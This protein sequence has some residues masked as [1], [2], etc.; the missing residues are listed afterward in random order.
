[1][2]DKQRQGR[3]NRQRGNA[4][5]RET[6]KKHG[7]RRT[8]MYGGPDDVTVDGL[9]K[10]QTKVGTMFSNKYWGWLEKIIVKAGEI[11]YL[12]IGDAPGAG[13]LRRVMVIMDER[14][15]IGIKE[16]LYGTAE[17]TTSAGEREPAVSK[18]ER[19]VQRNR[20]NICRQVPRRTK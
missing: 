10:I 3:L 20:S 8:G 7:G 2:T 15:W 9:F 19:S 12:V 13:A 1:M 5:E 18:V 11:P 14:D 4:F 17:E 16:K 6:A